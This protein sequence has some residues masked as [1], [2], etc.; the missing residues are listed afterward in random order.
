MRKPHVAVAGLLAGLVFV[1]GCYGPFYL[2]RKVHKFNGEVSD[3]KWVVELAF[4]AMYIIPVYSLAGAA[5]AII[6]NSIEFWTG[7]NPLT[8]TSSSTPKTKRIVRGEQEIL[9]SKLSTPAGEQL[10]IQQM[11]QG[12]PG[13]S[14]RMQ[15]EGEGMVAFNGEG[16]VVYR[17]HTL[18]DGGIAIADAQGQQVAQYSEDQVQ[19]FLKSSLQ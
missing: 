8:T 13:L 4:L 15:R 3:N 19:K 12:Q 11:T 10:L 17:A 18:A 16:E 14:L 2:V 7:E 5:D 6:F 1:S 9:L